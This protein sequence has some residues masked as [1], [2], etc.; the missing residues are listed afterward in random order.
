MVRSRDVG[1]CRTT[2][3]N[4][5]C[6]ASETVNLDQMVHGPLG[7]NS[8]KSSERPMKEKRIARGEACLKQTKLVADRLENT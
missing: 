2:F 4:K 6:G 8:K 5:K 7:L 1:A 3:A